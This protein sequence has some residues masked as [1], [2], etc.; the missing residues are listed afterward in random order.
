MSIAVAHLVQSEPV[1][2]EAVATRAYEKFIARGSGH[3]R[4]EED[5]TTAKA[6]LIAEA[7]GPKR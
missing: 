6:E 4:D 3:G 7:R 5:W 1:A 2:D